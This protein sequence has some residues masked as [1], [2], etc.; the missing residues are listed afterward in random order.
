MQLL[1]NKTFQLMVRYGIVGVAASAIHFAI[2]YISNNEFLLNPYLSH[3]LGFVFGL[4]TAYTGHYY[5][6]F[7]DNEKHSSRFPKFFVTALTA[8]ILHQGGV[9]VLVSI[10]NLNY[11]TQVLPL[12][13]LSVP[14]ITFL[15][16]K[17]WVFSDVK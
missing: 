8:L 5:Y 13:I 16:S 10:F 4:I 6:S 15:M 2:S 12:L 7:K 9:Y 11:S 3:L 1:N 17:F 14:M